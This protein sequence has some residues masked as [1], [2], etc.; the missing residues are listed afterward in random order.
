MAGCVLSV[1]VP[2][3]IGNLSHGRRGA[4]SMARRGM[5]LGKLVRGAA[6]SGLFWTVLAGLG[7]SW[8]P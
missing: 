6:G 1:F 4:S 5:H 3:W 7:K 8:A 2:V